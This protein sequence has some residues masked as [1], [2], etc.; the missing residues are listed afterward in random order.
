LQVDLPADQNDQS[1]WP[2]MKRLVADRFK[3]KTRDEWTAL[4]DHQEAC[5]TPVLSLNEVRLLRCC[6]RLSSFIQP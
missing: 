3:T 6:W 1:Q 4:F 2:A 5:V